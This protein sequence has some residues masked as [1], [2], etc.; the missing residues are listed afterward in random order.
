MIKQNSDILYAN[1]VRVKFV[2]HMLTGM[3]YWKEIKNLSDSCNLA[4]TSSNTQQ[5]PT[6]LSV[7]GEQCTC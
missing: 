6:K 1:K 4:I 3:V 7:A 2:C 5:S